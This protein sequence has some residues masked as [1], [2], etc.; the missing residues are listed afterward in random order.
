VF[1]AYLQPRSKR[2][3]AIFCLLAAVLSGVAY[4]RFPWR[5]ETMDF[6]VIGFFWLIRNSAKIGA[7]VMFWMALVA[8]IVL[9]LDAWLRE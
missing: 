1:L 2:I 5:N 7:A 9:W 3:L 6:D 4:L 8:A